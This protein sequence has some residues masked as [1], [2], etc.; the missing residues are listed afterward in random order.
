MEIFFEKS[1]E[2]MDKQSR[3]LY[4]ENKSRDYEAIIDI[5]LNGLNKFLTQ[6]NIEEQT[7]LIDGILEKLEKFRE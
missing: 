1:M 7:Q 5:V 6:K 4:A 3:L 2:K